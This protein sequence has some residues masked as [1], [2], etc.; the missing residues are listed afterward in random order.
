MGQTALEE[1]GDVITFEPVS[2]HDG[3]QQWRADARSQ[4]ITNTLYNFSLTMT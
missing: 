4:L 1:F 3:H 2:F